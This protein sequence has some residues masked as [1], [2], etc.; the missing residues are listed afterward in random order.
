MHVPDMRRLYVGVPLLFFASVTCN[1]P[2]VTVEARVMLSRMPLRSDTLT[3]ELTL[4]DKSHHASVLPTGEALFELTDLPRGTHDFY[5]E[6]STSWLQNSKN[7]VLL[8]ASKPNVTLTKGRNQ[9]VFEADDFEKIDNDSDGI[10]NW[11]EFVFGCDPT[12][13]APL[14]EW[15]GIST[16]RDHT[17]AIDVNRKAWCWGEND[18][19]QL[20]FSGNSTT[21]P[22]EPVN[23]WRTWRLVSAGS[24]HTCG[25]TVGDELYCWGDDSA[26][27]L[28]NGSAGGASAPDQIESDLWQEVSAGAEHTCGLQTNGTLWCWGKNDVGQLSLPAGPNQTTPQQVGESTAWTAVEVGFYHSCGLRAG[29]LYCWGDNQDGQI[30]GA[31]TGVYHNEPQP[32]QQQD[33]Q[34]WIA[35]SAGATNTCAINM[36][37]E[38]WC[39]GDNS[40]GEV[41]AVGGNQVEAGTR[42]LAVSIGSDHVCG[43]TDGEALLC[44]GSSAQGRLG[45][46]DA[47]RARSPA[48][49]ISVAASG[50]VAIAAGPLHTCA[51]QRGELWCW[52]AHGSGATG[53]G[54][55]TRGPDPMEEIIS[56]YGEA[57]SAGSDFTCAQG[58]LLWCWGNNEAWT[59]GTGSQLS[60][61]VPTQVNDRDSWQR[62]AAGRYHACA[63]NDGDL[64][65]WGTNGDRQLGQG[66]SDF[67][68]VP[69]RV[70]TET[71]WI[72]VAVGDYHTCGIREDTL[73]DLYCWGRH[74]D[75]ALGLGVYEADEPD[76]VMSGS[77][78][79]QVAAGDNHTCAIDV[80][81]QLHC[82]GANDRG[83]L[84]TGNYDQANLPHLIGTGWTAIAAGPLHTCGVLDEELMCWGANDHHQLGDGT[85]DTQHNT[86]RPVDSTE[87][88]W[89]TVSCGDMHTCAITSANEL[90][91]WGF[92]GVGQLGISSDN[93]Q[94]PALVGAGWL[95]VSAGD[96]HTCGIKNDN[97][98][99]CWGENLAG[100]TGNGHA[101]QDTPGPV[102]L[103]TE[104]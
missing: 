83:Q 96:Y 21:M 94:T 93:E 40:E 66:T 57:V 32:I 43:V 52:G 63:I 85:S 35:V 13:L 2:L 99:W 24:D 89:R 92:N 104:E 45:V 87:T 16:G 101:W 48:A 61:Q 41:G 22:T 75:G 9:V 42:W 46:G 28:G 71:G 47:G 49:V 51:I 38:L 58:G 60:V 36:G 76:Q 103:P 59:L 8:R 64:F 27:Q 10:D 54:V 79:N 78:W 30:P 100:Q 34:A 88:S 23:S 65:C 70:E 4:A 91:C 69:T 37:Q 55:L 81:T 98:I 39:W 15:V 11:T 5:M 18:S 26:G 77:E 19:H 90:Y 74:E 25:I 7:L 68:A 44:W 102:A 67:S 62:V 12:E 82:W 97:T 33:N 95:S 56:S 14:C 29:E 72:D 86:P 50:W 31:E 80:N 53:L 6:I 84:G 20:G 17:C 73:K 3:A 1:E